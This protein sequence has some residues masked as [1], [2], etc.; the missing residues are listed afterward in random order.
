MILSS[1]GRSTSRSHFVWPWM[2]ML[3]VSV[4]RTYSNIQIQSLSRFVSDPPNLFNYQNTFHSVTFSLN[5]KLSTERES[6]FSCVDN[7]GCLHQARGFSNVSKAGNQNALISKWRLT[8]LF[9]SELK[10]PHS[11]SISYWICK[12]LVSVLFYV[13]LIWRIFNPRLNLI[14]NGFELT[15]GMSK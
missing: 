8:V 13:L 11:A 7:N 5:L 12:S 1:S 14:S 9:L 2:S 10:C 3:A 6:D 15:N 4:S